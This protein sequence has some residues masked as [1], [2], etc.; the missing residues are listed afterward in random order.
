M[1]EEVTQSNWRER[2]APYPKWVS[3]FY[4][5]TNSQSAHMFLLHGE[6]V[7]D[8]VIGTT[9]LRPFLES[10]L[11]PSAKERVAPGEKNHLLVFYNRARGIVFGADP[12]NADPRDTQ[13]E[14]ARK[15]FEKVIGRLEAAQQLQ[16]LL[17]GGASR[18][19]SQ[20][21]DLPALESQPAAVMP[22]FDKLLAQK[23][24]EVTLVIEAAET[25]CPN[26]EFA[27]MTPEDR[28][29]L[30]LFRS[31]G[32]DIGIGNRGHSI[33]VT[34][35]DVSNLHP[36]LR[37][38]TSGA[39]SL[40]APLPDF[41]RRLKFIGDLADAYAQDGEE[42]LAV[43]PVEFAGISAGLPYRGIEDIVLQAVYEE[44]PVDRAMIL[45]RK[46]D[47]I[48]QSY[49][50]VIEV[51]DPESGFEDVGGLD[52]VKDWFQR[53]V[54]QPLRTGNRKRAKKGAIL[55]GPPGTGKT[56]LSMAVA[57]ESGVTCCVLN[58]ALILGHY[59]GDS[60]R[61]MRRALN[62]IWSLGHT[63]V[64]VDEFD[65]LGFNRNSEGDSGV[66]SRLMKQ[67]MEAMGSEKGRGR[68]FWLAATNRPDLLDAAMIRDGRFDAKIPIL[69][70]VL[71]ERESIL[72]V[73]GVR[74]FG[75]LPEAVIKKVAEQTE[76]WT[77]A[78]MEAF[79]L[80]A[81]ELLEDE[82]A[83]DVMGAFEL[84]RQLYRP[85]TREIEQQSRYALAICNDYDLLPE[86]VRQKAEAAKEQ[87][88]QPAGDDED[89]ED[90]DW[91]GFARHKGKGRK[92][93]KPEKG[94][95]Q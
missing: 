32:Q 40:E 95:E 4:G 1:E 74:F 93:I 80:K 3:Q 2:L 27:A 11:R 56:K 72:K 7:D 16:S 49:G 76:S 6:G 18:K 10:F 12:K 30:V 85:T 79:C 24:V 66:G 94:E 73:M 14:A 22:L 25:L 48:A 62:L 9:A 82:R 19:A 34:T 84:A 43:E 54:I 78:E 55:A 46:R 26:A 64:F 15:L 77:G 92:S 88:G 35:G 83:S 17:P 33:L 8:Y 52:R 38:A 60:E 45:D 91:S 70:P 86:A 71:E 53:N 31:W 67:L 90:D 65:Q 58:P 20:E 13:R 44:M 69:P 41:D 36:S 75:E 50:E 57:R 23:E 81:W 39:R 47:M 37:E 5:L 61:A 63:V 89:D 42:V 51:M 87:A 68:V 21:N 29:M 59:V 28:N